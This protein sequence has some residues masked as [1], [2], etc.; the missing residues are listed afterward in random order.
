MGKKRRELIIAIDGPAG[1]GKSTV[2]KALACK[3]NYKY[4]DTGATYRAFAWKSKH[5]KV[6]QND[7]TQLELLV[8][9]TSIELR[10]D[11]GNFRVYV[12]G[13][14]VTEEI[15]T[16]EM[17][18]L[19]SHISAFQGVRKELTVLQ[20]KLGEKGG[21]VIEGRD[22]GTVVFPDADLKFFLDATLEERAHRRKDEIKKK[23]ISIE[24][25]NI[26]EEIRR[27]DFNDSNRE[28]APLTM[29][30]DAIHI[31]TTGISVDDVV[32]IMKKEVEKKRCSILY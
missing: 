24:L 30:V 10:C 11:S 27:R 23:G 25:E 19:S 21:A 12:D 3:L 4:I 13:N 28:T 8:K 2:A 14:D 17:S 22:V 1:A 20:R 5:E 9:R 32:S 16:E 18:K 7:V 26:I 31:D 6:S 15:R 29:A